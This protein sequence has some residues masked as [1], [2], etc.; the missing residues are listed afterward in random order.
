M[1]ARLKLPHLI[2][3]SR[4]FVQMK[5]GRAQRKCYLTIWWFIHV[6]DGSFLR[7]ATK[8]LYWIVQWYRFRPRWFDKSWTTRRDQ[9]LC[10]WRSCGVFLRYTS[11]VSPTLPINCIWFSVESAWRPYGFDRRYCYNLEVNFEWKREV[12]LPLQNHWGS[13]ASGWEKGF[14]SFLCN[15]QGFVCQ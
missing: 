3:G 11:Q 13:T 4:H 2:D 7:R 12:L 10:P 8:S 9:S 15:R 14:P 5:T 1:F 6:R